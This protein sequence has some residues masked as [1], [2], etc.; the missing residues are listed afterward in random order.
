MSSFTLIVMESNSLNGHRLV[1]VGSH[2]KDISLDLYPEIVYSLLDASQITFDQ[3]CVGIS[4]VK[5]ISA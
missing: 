2:C 1:C 3:V 4:Q 5:L